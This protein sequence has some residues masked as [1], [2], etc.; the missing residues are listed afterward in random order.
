MI[1]FCL[2]SALLMGLVLSV[3]GRE[4]LKDVTTLHLPGERYSPVRRASVGSAHYAADTSLR[5][6][7]MEH[8]QLTLTQQQ[9]TVSHHHTFTVL[10]LV[11]LIHHIIINKKNQSHKKV[12][13]ATT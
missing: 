12:K 3:G 6:L 2:S 10:R 1:I 5:E 13:K 7:Q 9:T 8:Q 4:G 11:H